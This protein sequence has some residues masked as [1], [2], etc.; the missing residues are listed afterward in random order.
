MSGRLIAVVG[1]SGVGK[2]SLIAALA[3]VR[4]SLH[5]VRRA[6]TRPADDSEPFESVTGAEFDRRRAAGAFALEWAAHGLRYGIPVEALERARGGVEVIANVSR[7]VLP[8]AVQLFPS[9]IAL[10]IIAAPAT[11]ARRLAARGREDEADIAARLARPAPPFP[12]GLLV[13]ELSNDGT[14]E[15]TVDLAQKALVSATAP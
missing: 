15:V 2:D 5:V 12:P 9:C 7:S 11:L 13:V 3:R 8:R 1:P 14:L 10:S 4:P 6:I